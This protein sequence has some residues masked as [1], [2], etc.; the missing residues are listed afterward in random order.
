MKNAVN[1]I[2]KTIQKLTVPSVSLNINP[3]QDGSVT[4]IRK[5]KKNH[6]TKHASNN[7]LRPVNLL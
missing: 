6:N 2:T 3:T 7:K 4:R 5:R 1:K